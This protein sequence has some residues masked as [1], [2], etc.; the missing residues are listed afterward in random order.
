[1]HAVANAVAPRAAVVATAAASAAAST[2]KQQEHW[3]RTNFVLLPMGKR[4]GPR[5]CGGR[6]PLCHPG[7]HP[8]TMDGGPRV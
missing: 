5:D 7:R 4:A 3:L 6:Y 1:M 8:A 2:Y